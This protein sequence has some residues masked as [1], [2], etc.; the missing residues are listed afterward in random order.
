MAVNFD[1]SRYHDDFFEIPEEHI[2]YVKDVYTLL[3]NAE[4]TILLKKLC[5]FTDTVDQL[6]HVI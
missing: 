5:F 4:I 1:I 6:G 3:Q 2:T